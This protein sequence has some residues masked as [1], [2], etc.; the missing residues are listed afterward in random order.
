MIFHRLRLINKDQR[1]F[2]LTEL[3]LAICI[4]AIITAFITLTIFQVITG[5]A[6]TNNHMTAVRQAQSAGYWVSHDAMMAQSIAPP[7]GGFPLTLTWTEWADGGPNGDEHEVVYSLVDGASG[8]LK[9][10]QRSY[11][12]NGTTETSIV[13]QFIDPTEKDGEPQTKCEF[14][15]GK[16]TFKVTATV[17]KQSETRTYEVMPRPG[18]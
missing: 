2:T 13:A 4:S 7:A 11:S 9:S 6:R 12:V 8:G 3:I 17:G 18:S 14:A 1:G 10:L 15:G 16:L 5:S